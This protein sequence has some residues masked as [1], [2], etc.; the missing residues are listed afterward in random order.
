MMNPVNGFRFTPELGQRL[1]QLRLKSGFR[2]EDV[3]QRM[4]RTGRKSS[5]LISRLESGKTRRPSFGLIADYLRACGATFADI[6]DLLPAQQPE[7]EKQRRPKKPKSREEKIRL[8]RNRAATLYRTRMFEE[9]LFNCLND[10]NMFD[11]YEQQKALAEYGRKLLNLLVN[12]RNKEKETRHKLLQAEN[13]GPDDAEGM[14]RLMN[15]LFDRM[16]ANGDMDRKTPVDAAAVVDGRAKLPPVVKAERRLLKEH[17]HRLKLWSESRYWVFERVKNESK[18]LH[19][20]L[21]LEGKEIR[22]Y[23]NVVTDF[24]FI[25]AETEP[26]SE[27]RSRRFEERIARATDKKSVRRIGEFAMTRY[28]ELKHRIPKKPKGLERAKRKPES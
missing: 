5:T 22:P 6:A 1:R 11:T 20:E 15:G 23:L 12:V 17:L 7:S 26:D 10:P 2:Q 4:G 24:C 18:D 28:D 13:V 19:P 8:V 25:A 3:A 9:M 14:Y 27:E 16:K 21:G